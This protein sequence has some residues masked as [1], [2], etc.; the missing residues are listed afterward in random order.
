MRIVAPVAALAGLFG[1]VSTQRHE[2]RAAAEGRW[3]IDLQ[4]IEDANGAHVV[5]FV[6]ERREC[7]GKRVNDKC[8]RPRPGLQVT[9]DGLVFPVESAGFVGLTIAELAQA[10]HEFNQ[11]E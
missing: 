4:L 8:T 10:E 2:Q 5:P 1:C 6:W 7:S 11:H 9:V 3:T